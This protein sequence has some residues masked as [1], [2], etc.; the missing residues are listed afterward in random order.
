MLFQKSQ[1]VH[2]MVSW[3]DSSFTCICTGWKCCCCFFEGI[4]SILFLNCSAFSLVDFISRSSG[5]AINICATWYSFF[6]FFFFFQKCC[7]SSCETIILL[8]DNALC[9]SFLNIISLCKLSYILSWIHTG[10]V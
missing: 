10:L 8:D 3:K 6:G 9:L 2:L 7:I 1:V 5:K 4:L